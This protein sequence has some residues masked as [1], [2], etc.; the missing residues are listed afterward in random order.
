MVG[1]PKPDP[2]ENA[3]TAEA[4]TM[5]APAGAPPP[6]RRQTTAQPDHTDLLPVEAQHYVL[7]FEIARGGMGRIVAARDRRLRRPVAVKELLPE[8][9]DARRFERE[10]LITA[11][12]Q[13]PSIVRIYEAGRWKDGS[14]FYAMEMV[15]GRSLDKVIAEAKTLDARLALLPHV[16]AVAD[17]LAYAHAQHIVH[18]DLKP[19]NVLVAAFGQTVV[20]D[21]GLAKDLLDD[22]STIEPTPRNAPHAPGLTMAGSVMGTPAYMAPEQARGID[23]DERADVYALGALLY[24]TLAGHAPFRGNSSDEVLK[25]VLAHAPPALPDIVPGVPR[26][27]AAIVDK[28]MA[29]DAAARYPSAGELAE[30]LRRFQTGRL[31]AA[32]RYT[33]GELVRRWIGRHR[34]V[35]ATASAALA[36]VVTM[37]ALGLSSIVHERNRARVAQRI[38]EAA[39]R[40][41][42]Q[43]KQAAVV[44]ADDLVLAQARSALGS[45]PSA[46]L[47]WL[48]T[49]PPASPETTWTA[50]RELAADAVRRGV[51]QVLRG[52]ADDVNELVYSP[53]GQWLASGSEEGAVRLW[54]AHGE[55]RLLRGHGSALEVIRFAP[56]S[57]TL[58]SGS[59]D[60]KAMVWNVADGV[61]RVLAGHSGTVRGAGISAGGTPATAGE[62]GTLRFWP[63]SGAPVVVNVGVPLRSVVWV[64]DSRVVVTGEDGLVM[65]YDHS[66]KPQWKGAER[67]RGIVRGLV[68]GK[69][70][71][72]TGGEDHTV[73]AWNTATGVSRLI[74]THDD[75]VRDLALSPDERTLASGASDRLVKLWDLTTGATR[76]LRGHES[77]IK[78]VAY[79]PDGKWV[80]SAGGDGVI[81]LWDAVSGAGRTLRGHAAQVDELAFA[82]DSLHLASSSDDDTVR[83]WALGDA[84]VVPSE[85]AALLAWMAPLTNLRVHEGAVR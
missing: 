4:H 48:S 13:H 6:A 1:R 39:E 80:A 53:D 21:W 45:D 58:I 27:L 72:Y 10:A 83:V 35:V 62:D 60:Q 47:A 75:V 77:A 46:T 67:H 30:E 71:I 81:W 55:G 64:D 25:A 16:I 44:R 82:P 85:P 49:L 57:K 73:R 12:L 52:H 74:G 69:E 20:I 17:A 59:M 22:A 78:T 70:T 63:A 43:A 42:T 51:S 37:G 34:A 7:G 56:D 18:R 79:S 36:V 8:A 9:G 33:R 76:V 26:A 66:G 61:P 29:F 40:E 19:S 24:C 68:V 23:V 5:V 84:G 41:A 31:V 2:L 28:A 32:H 50:A 38:A 54:D 14:P 15:N 3:Q 65:V 11:R